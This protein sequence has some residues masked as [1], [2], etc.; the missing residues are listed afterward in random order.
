MLAT[1]KGKTL[2]EFHHEFLN[3][4]NQ[5]VFKV[6]FLGV[7]IQCH[8][9]KDA[10]IFDKLLRNLSL[11]GRQSLVEVGQRRA[12]ALVKFGFDLMD[13]YIP[14]PAVLN[15]GFDVPFA[16]VLGFDFV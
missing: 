16:L 3:M 8:E 4:G 15:G 7:G 6:A 12:L 14:R 10:R 13:K 11:S 9:I 2:S 1:D 5:R